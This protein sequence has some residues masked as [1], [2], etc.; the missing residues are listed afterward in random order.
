MKQTQIKEQIIIC[1]LKHIDSSR[2]IVRDLCNC[3]I[4]DNVLL[5]KCASKLN[6]EAKVISILHETSDIIEANVLC[7]I[8]SEFTRAQALLK[9]AQN[10]LNIQRTI[11]QSKL[12]NMDI[13]DLATLVIN[14]PDVSTDIHN[15]L[16]E[17]LIQIYIANNAIA[18]AKKILGEDND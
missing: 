2:I 13:V 17:S 14:S 4:G 7:R 15:S 12:K 6:A 5:Q 9:D 18:Q 8:D 3:R 16:N 10:D 11:L 1:E